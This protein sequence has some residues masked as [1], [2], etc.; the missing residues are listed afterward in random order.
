[1]RLSGLA[2]IIGNSLAGGHHG[3]AAFTNQYSAEFD[4]VDDYIATD[5]IYSPLDGGTKASF[6]VWVKPVSGAPKLEYLFHNPRNA[7]ANQG[8]F[9]LILYESNRIELYVQAYN[10]QKVLGDITYIT[11]GSWNHILVTVDLALS[12]GNEGKVYINGVDRTTSSAMGTLANFYG[13]TD[14]LYIGEEATGGYNP[15]D[16]KIDE[17]AIWAGTTL[18]PSDVSSIYNSGTPTD[19]S[20]FGTPPT[21]WWRMGDNNGGPPSTVLTDAI[22]SANA[23]LINGTAYT[24]D[25]P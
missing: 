13:A 15:Y 21:N 9:G 24:T 6:S 7:T 2:N 25:V 8:Q 4:G 19:L 20:A 5:A 22:G 1:M 3:A 16:G 18:T 14:K 17:L 23:T 12:A 10:A 11:Y